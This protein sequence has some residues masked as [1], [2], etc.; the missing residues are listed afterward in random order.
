MH[1]LVIIPF[2]FSHKWAGCSILRSTCIVHTVSYGTRTQ[3]RKNITINNWCVVVLTSLSF[4]LVFRWSLRLFCFEGTI[5]FL[6]LLYLPGQNS[7]PKWAC[8]TRHF[9]Y[10]I[11]FFPQNLKSGH[12]LHRDRSKGNTNPNGRV[13]RE[14]SGGKSHEM[15][16]KS[17]R[18]FGLVIAKIYSQQ[19]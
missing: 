15:K 13:K 12:R 3:I 7:Q 5:S 9:G 17:T 8:K 14:K 18:P 11:D 10:G 1:S 16:A 6:F 2:L 4:D 19:Q